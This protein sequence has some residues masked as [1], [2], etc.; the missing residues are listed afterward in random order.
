MLKNKPIVGFTLILL[1]IAAC[2][3][4]IVTNNSTHPSLTPEKEYSAS[5]VPSRFTVS[6]AGETKR[7]KWSNEMEFPIRAMTQPGHYKVISDVPVPLPVPGAIG[8]RIDASKEST[9]A[10]LA[11]SIHPLNAPSP[12][13]E[14][15]LA[16]NPSKVTF[17]TAKK[18]I[19]SG[20]QGLDSY[21]VS[22]YDRLK[23]K[24]VAR[25][26]GTDNILF[27]LEVNFA[28]Q[29]NLTD[30]APCILP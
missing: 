28:P 24:V 1:F 18:Q 30:R 8:M 9:G 4:E 5:I 6:W 7:C 17:N 11:V 19:V 27:S 14:V 15:E 29:W 22:D 26:T 23:T 2:S 13:G 21:L 12:I 10:S 25:D 20:I 3:K 16:M